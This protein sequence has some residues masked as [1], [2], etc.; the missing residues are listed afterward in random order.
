MFDDLIQTCKVEVSS[1]TNSI[2][3]ARHTQLS[4]YYD[5]RNPLAPLHSCASCGRREISKPLLPHE[6][7]WLDDLEQVYE[8]EAVLAKSDASPKASVSAA[9]TRQQ[10]H[11]IASGKQLFDSISSVTADKMLD[12]YE[13]WDY[14]T[15]DTSGGVPPQSR[16]FH[17]HRQFVDEHVG[18]DYVDMKSATSSRFVSKPCSVCLD[19]V[20]VP[21]FRH[22]HVHRDF[23]D[24]HIQC[25]RAISTRSYVADNLNG[26]ADSPCLL[27]ADDN[28]ND[29]QHVK[30]RSALLCRSCFDDNRRRTTPGKSIAAG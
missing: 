19:G 9:F 15:D 17:L 14:T 3:E 26:A 4:G 18:C 7:V 13:A 11:R 10:L 23:V 25:P 20:C 2:L 16:K 5:A 1:H 24:E 8:Y 27:C 22:L 21:T 28:T 12:Y 30:G 29:R 6:R